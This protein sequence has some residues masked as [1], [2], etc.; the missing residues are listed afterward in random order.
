MTRYQYLK[1][2]K[3]ID[4]HNNAHSHEKPNKDFILALIVT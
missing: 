4:I 3:F 1:V 2:E